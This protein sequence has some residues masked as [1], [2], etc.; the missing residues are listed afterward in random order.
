[1]PPAAG[2]EQ[3]A[4][5]QGASMGVKE[6][7]SRQPS[8]CRCK[9]R[10]VVSQSSVLMYAGAPGYILIA[11]PHQVQR[12]RERAANGECVT[13][14]TCG[15]LQS[16]QACLHAPRR[17]GMHN[18]CSALHA[19]PP[20]VNQITFLARATLWSSFHWSSA[21]SSSPVSH[22]VSLMICG[23]SNAHKC[24]A[25]YTLEFVLSSSFV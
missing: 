18:E 16:I 9:L 19:C 7:I 13:L 5:Q 1:M 12:E 14:S 2:Q 22:T 25:G 11:M 24:G 10:G 8:C 4:Q 21:S 15:W 20:P 17:R 6:E 23:A 3:Q